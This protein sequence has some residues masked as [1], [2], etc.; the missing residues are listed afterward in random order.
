M[1]AISDA[2]ELQMY[3]MFAMSYPSGE[4]IY[5]AISNLPDGWWPY[6][7]HDVRSILLLWLVLYIPGYIQWFV[8]PASIA[9]AW[10]RVKDY[11]SP[12]SAL[13]E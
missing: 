13:D 1:R 3:A 7:D 6:S 9:A 5:S 12:K 10:R 11:R 2:L 4:W 8:L